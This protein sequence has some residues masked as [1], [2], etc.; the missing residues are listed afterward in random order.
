[1]KMSVDH[2]YQADLSRLSPV[3]V[4][5]SVTRATALDF[6]KTLAMQETRFS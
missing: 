3:P 5:F 4:G 6:A 1:M 2:E